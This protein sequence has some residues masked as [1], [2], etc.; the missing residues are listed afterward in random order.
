MFSFL[1]QS[2]LLPALVV[3]LLVIPIT[4]VGV[5]KTQRQKPP[6]KRR[7]KA[8][9]VASKPP[10]VKKPEL[11]VQN[12]HSDTVR[13]LAFSPDGK[14]LA[15]ASSDKTVRLWETNTGKM[16]RVLDH[17]R[18]NVTSIAFSP[19]GKTIASGSL[20]KTVQ[21]C[22]VKS[23]QLIRSLQNHSEQ[24]N[25][26]AFSPDGKT[27]ASG[28]LDE[29]INLW[30][31]TTG[32]IILTIEGIASD[33]RAVAF[34]PDGTTLASGSADKIV[35]I[36]HVSDGQLVR[37]CS[38]DSSAIRTV[39]FSPDGLII[40]SAGD[41]Y[42]IKV[43]NVET[44]L[45]IRTLKGHSGIVTSIV[46]SKD[47]KLLFSGS[48]DKAIRVWEIESGKNL[49]TLEA[50]SSP[51]LAVTLS[52]DGNNVAV[53][54]WTSVD[55]RDSVTGKRLRTFE[56]RLS[57]IRAVAFSPDGKT[58]ALATGNKIKI[59][60]CVSGALAHT[61]EGHSSQINALA[62]SPDGR[63]LASGGADRTIKLW[64][65][66][67]NKPIRELTGH[68]SSVSAIAFGPDSRFIASGSIDKTVRLW[69]VQ[70]GESVRTFEGHVSLV[71]AIAFAPNG[72]NIASGSYDNSIK[73][74]NVADG[75]TLYTLAGHE[76]EVTGIAFSPDGTLLAS[77][78]RDKTVRLW[79]PVTGQSIRTLEGNAAD[80]FAVSFS[81]D[82]K[83]LAS[84]G[85]DKAVRLWNPS[86]GQ[87]VRTL[88]G[89]S[90]PVVA[91]AY[92]PDGK[93]IVSGSDDASAK[94]WA[95]D[96]FQALSTLISFNDG[97]EWL[98]V[99]PEGLFDGSP[100]GWNAILWRFASNTFDV[101]PVE[102]FF[103]EYYYPGLLA[104][105][106]AGK[107]TSAAQSIASV[108][109]R[110]PKVKLS[111]VDS[112]V[113][114]DHS[115]ASRRIAVR[116]QVDEALPDT[117]HPAGCG[118]RDVR[119]FRN[120]A[121]IRVWHG[122]VLGSQS[123]V[124]LEETISL[125]AGE[126][127]L[128]A[129]GFNKDNIKS[130]DD[131]ISLTGSDGLKRKGVLYVLTVGVNEYA[132]PEYNLRYAGADAQEF[133]ETLVREQSKLGSF[134][135][136]ELISLVNQD[137]T[138]ANILA[139]LDRL[140]AGD[141][142][143]PPNAPA[144]LNRIKPAEPEDAVIIFFA[145]HGTAQKARFYLIPHDLGYD[146]PRDA[147]DQTRLDSLLAHSISDQEL[148]RAFEHIDAGDL[149][150]VLD[151]CNSGQALES[152]EKRRGP[153]NSVGL[154]QLAYEKGIYILTAAQAYQA[155]LEAS[156]LGHGFL[157]YALVEEGLKNGEAD[158]E[159]KDGKILIRE[160]VDFAVGRVPEMQAAALRGS[161]GLKIVFAQG[162]EKVPEPAKRNVQRPRVFYRREPEPQPLV[163]EKITIK[164]K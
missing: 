28:S 143:L 68:I 71:S 49:R 120:G 30:D 16:L 86:N 121:L 89:H 136:F 153:M 35:R 125:V 70:S 17:H 25:T 82:G 46:F 73:I 151:A 23:G 156:E 74:W 138:K 150:M 119:L 104:D 57:G 126:N 15:S 101:A 137:A 142:E 33:V 123:G 81:P 79:D 99:T 96:N 158:R 1:S 127:R 97:R 160:W 102:A 61:L 13:A 37:A 7:T 155:A 132:N 66:S 162:D 2:R 154:A 20:D 58:L 100:Q 131:T 62:F 105:I 129:Y 133:G 51:I 21:L 53:G 113:G 130:A 90:G 117:E 164:H 108:D 144:A 85:Y 52:P 60:D 124:A 118:A 32:E 147:L 11:V 140:A 95:P 65:V 98:T 41:D 145:G 22:D 112:R 6:V 44:G 50:A 4:V 27:I 10:A 77:C 34:S 42:A 161:R 39:A 19:D 72:K 109:R 94:V 139:A 63:L 36:W 135:R 8:P 26:I 84:A 64:D 91:L 14:L 122:D 29:T 78:G 114:P 67:S 5:Q 76:S 88:E 157:T 45:A 48:H 54:N 9:E 116:I 56:A 146:G 92:S 83:M 141:R 3:A 115:I 152:E 59:W 24:V 93:F 47:G 55:L 38:G 111:T 31:A 134:A 106:L 43:W 149:L 163:L 128:T 18:D 107:K 103:N 40:A 110:Q 159:P 148:E 12:G 87:L 69:D 80:V 75:K